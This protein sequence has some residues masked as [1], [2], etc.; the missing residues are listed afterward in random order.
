MTTPLYEFA[1][2]GGGMAGASVAYRLAPSA[3]VVLLERESQ[4]GYHTTGRS[5]A[6]FMES[7]GPPGVR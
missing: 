6:M 5:A 4:P 1:I 2:V 3:S 7:Y